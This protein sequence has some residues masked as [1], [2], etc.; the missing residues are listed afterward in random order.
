MSN[1][2]PLPQSV[3][4]DL[5]ARR[6]G[7]FIHW[8]LYAIAGY[9]EQHQQR[10]NVPRKE[11]GQFACQFNPDR[12][13]PDEWALLA[14]QA[15]LEYLILT[16]KHHDGFCLWNTQTTPFSVNHTPFQQDIVK[17]VAE[18]CSRHGIRFGI[19]YSCVD[20]HHPNYPNMGRHHE[21]KPQPG[22]QPD[23]EKYLDF[24]RAQVRELCDGRYGKICAFWWDMNVP[25]HQ[26][27]SINRLIKELQPEC[28]INNRGYGPGD[29]STPEREW[30]SDQ[31]W[32]PYTQTVEANNSVDSLS[33]GFRCDPQFY[34]SQHL[35]GA[36]CK[37]V[38]RGG[39]YLINVGPDASGR[40]TEPYQKRL[41]EIGSWFQRVREAL[42]NT[43]VIE[44]LPYTQ[45]Q[46]LTRRGNTLYLQLVQTPMSEGICLNPICIE[47]QRATLMNSGEAVDY[48][49]DCL[50]YEPD[51]TRQFLRLKL[52]TRM[53]TPEVPVIRLEFATDP[54]AGRKGLGGAAAER[55]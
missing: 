15:G 27:P 21:L 44:P 54:L 32:Q 55:L 47:P 34:T 49:I 26:D 30:D 11:Y 20:W 43:D 42:V 17:A 18:A 51:R 23:M 39:N 6:L 31:S 24:V 36:I 16:A 48:S 1:T 37:Y 38:S 12:F 45:S 25:E 41:L 50:P 14:K 2:I 4:N 28:L 53:F 9:H 29:F 22:D 33:W 40:I 35:Q 7:L 3:E 13:A 46:I 8:G 10:L 52:P 5:F 19:Y